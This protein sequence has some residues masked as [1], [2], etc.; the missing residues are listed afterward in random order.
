L[1]LRSL[2]GRLVVSALLLVAPPTN[3]SADWLFTGFLGSTFAGSTTHLDL[4]GGVGA[5]QVIYGATVGWLSQSIIGVEAEFAYA[6]RFFETDNRAGPVTG[7]HV[8]TLMGS[9]LVTLPLSVTRESLRPYLV[10]GI[11]M[12]QNGSATSLDFVNEFDPQERNVL[13]VNMGGGAIGF[14]S[15]DVGVRFDLR[16]IRS[17]LRGTNPLTGEPGTQLRFWRVTV[18]VA[19]RL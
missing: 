10:G 8:M 17:L 4:E 16:H 19:L 6:P 11:G 5:N 9:V 13:G 14:V 18:G 3:A 2:S 12:M 1:R 7:S 15:P